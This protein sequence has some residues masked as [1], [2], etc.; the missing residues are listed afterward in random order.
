MI[1][2]YN[3]FVYTQILL[4]NLVLTSVCLSIGWITS[5]T[6]VSGGQAGIYAWCELLMRYSKIFLCILWFCVSEAVQLL[7]CFP[8]EP[9]FSLNSHRFHVSC[10]MC[11]VSH[12]TCHLSLVT[13]ADSHSHRP[14]SSISKCKKNHWNNKNWKMS[15]CMPILAIHS[16]TRSP[17]SSGKQLSRTGTD[18]PIK[19]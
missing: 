17:K 2:L 14:S 11:H 12:V 1:F 3:L 4:K 5:E 19:L 18:T 16:L 9:I 10:V 13:N 7:F 6:G 15:R 8:L